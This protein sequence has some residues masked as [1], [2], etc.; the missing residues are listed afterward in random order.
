VVAFNVEVDVAAAE[1]LAKPFLEC[2]AAP[3]FQP[4]AVELLAAKKNLRSCARTS[5]SS[6]AGRHA[7][8]ARGALVQGV[9]PARAA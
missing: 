4:P 2:V 9:R 6:R 7:R 8:S 1:A 5:P 3:S